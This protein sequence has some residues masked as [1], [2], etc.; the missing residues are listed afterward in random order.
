MS[1]VDITL[2]LPS[3]NPPID[4]LSTSETTVVPTDNNQGR[5][6][7]LQSSLN[8]LA[9]L[10]DPWLEKTNSSDTVVVVTVTRLLWNCLA[11]GSDDDDDNNNVHDAFTTT[12]TTSSNIMNLVESDA[13]SWINEWTRI[14][15]LI[16]QHNNDDCDCVKRKEYLSP[17][18]VHTIAS[19]ALQFNSST[20]SSS[21]SRILFPTTC[22]MICCC[23]LGRYS[24]KSTKY[25]QRW[26]SLLFE[27]LQLYQ[28]QFLRPAN[29]DDND[30]DDDN[31]SDK[32]VVSR[33]IG[34]HMSMS[35][36]LLTQYIIPNI[37]HVRS[38]LLLVQ[39]KNGTNAIHS[40][41][42]NFLAA[43]TAAAIF[44]LTHV[45]EQYHS[46][47]HLDNSSEVHIKA[48]IMVNVLESMNKVMEGRFD[49]IWSHAL[50]IN[51]QRRRN[52]EMNP[53]EK[54]TTFESALSFWSCW[55]QDYNGDEGDDDDDDDG[56]IEEKCTEYVCFVQTVW[57]SLG[58]ALSAAC[59]YNTHYR[60]WVWHP[61][62]AWK[63]LFPHV[64]ILLEQEENTIYQRFAFSLLHTLLETT[65]NG[66]LPPIHGISW[67]KEKRGGR[68]DHPVVQT[69][70]LLSN[71]IMRI[72]PESQM[73]NVGNKWD[74]SMLSLPNGAQCFAM[75]MK[76]L[77][78]KYIPINQV[79]LVRHLVQT[80][81]HVGLKPKLLDLLRSFVYWN[82]NDMMSNCNNREAQR[83]AWKF[84]DDQ[85]G[86]ITR[87]C[88]LPGPS[89]MTTATLSIRW[90]QLV[91]H[92]ELGVAILSMI[93]LW[94]LVHSSQHNDNSSSSSRS[95]SSNKNEIPVASFHHLQA[96]SF[97][98][99]QTALQTNLQLWT[100]GTTSVTVCNRPDEYHRLYLLE[101]AF[102]QTIPLL[103]LDE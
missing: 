78:A 28:R 61:S 22:L 86:E 81:P 2:P 92:V 69:F 66:S 30:D 21:S 60:P 73:P 11:G 10:T 38:T 64:P 96:E 74:G 16:R 80:C 101:L 46:C 15:S 102:E 36:L 67:I 59:G 17:F 63:L 82:S 26:K 100:S 58:V 9:T 56:S 93:R 98:H 52:H 85:W 70:Q 23:V 87:T 27:T 34:Y 62:Y 31:G 4:A 8:V 45:M 75:F 5:E 51:N 103:A 55:R 13:T 90:D 29:Y 47:P 25:L 89:T 19:Q 40:S 1:G 50:R 7:E 88:C 54:E 71:Y 68:P 12:T 48:P 94:N 44:S 83:A 39:Q 14:G 20:S 33:E 32:F 95:S 97:W 6:D 84:L 43:T 91:D 18:Q 79:L 42:P 35:A 65:P 53:F 41:S 3:S 77:L 49:L 76:P 24:E 37:W 57:D 72:N 99:I